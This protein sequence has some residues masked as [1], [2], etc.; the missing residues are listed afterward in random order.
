MSKEREFKELNAFGFYQKRLSLLLLLSTIPSCIISFRFLFT[1]YEPEF[2][3]DVPAALSE[4]YTNVTESQYEYLLNATVPWTTNDKQELV[5]SEC[6]NYDIPNIDALRN[7]SG[8]GRVVNST[9]P[10]KRWRFAQDGVSALTEL[11]FVCERAWMKPFSFTAYAFGQMCG[12]FAVRPI[13]DIF[14]RRRVF[15]TTLVLQYMV[16]LILSFSTSAPMYMSVVFLTGATDMVYGTAFALGIETTS[17]EKRT[18]I[19]FC[20][21]MGYSLGFLVLTFLGYF[22]RDWRWLLRAF[23]FTAIFYIP[24]YWLIDESPR[25]LSSVGRE[26][27]SQRILS[28]IA[29]L[30]KTHNIPTHDLEKLKTNLSGF[31]EKE[32]VKSLKFFEVSK[33]VL[34]QP[35]LL[36]RLFI[37]FFAWYCTSLTYYVIGLNSNNLSENRFL[38]LC[39]MGLVDIAAT[40]GYYLISAKIGRRNSY[41]FMMLGLALLSAITPFAHKLSIVLVV[42]MVCVCKFA[43]SLLFTVIFVHT[44]ELFPTTQRQST[45]GISNAMAIIGSLT[46]PYIL[47]AGDPTRVKIISIAIGAVLLVSSAL[48]RLLPK[49]INVSLPQT[50]DDAIAMGRTDTTCLKLRR[51]KSNRDEE[52]TLN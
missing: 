20:C 2:H 44:T 37:V 17:T 13:S 51:A 35:V 14:G 11:K 41:V 23:S 19:T 26:E 5:R 49:T 48:Y 50:M 43:A 34:K 46:A 29:K 31:P 39:L 40:V 1:V 27:E 38:N 7:E 12:T 15:L 4:N 32:K 24:Y 9:S 30:N 36:K 10:C 16:C 8:T 25:W 22:F 28:K 33:L 6:F 3:C 52:V 45:L 47:F 21:Q 42:V 18:F